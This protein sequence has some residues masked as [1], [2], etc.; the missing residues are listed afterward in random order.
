[1]LKTNTLPSRKIIFI[2]IILFLPGK[3]QAQN[4]YELNTFSDDFKQIMKQP[5]KWNGSDLLI[6]SGAAAITYGTMHYDSAIKDLM[7]QNKK[8]QYTLPVEFGRIWGEPWAT[9]AIGGS[10]YIHGSASDNA[11]NKKIGFEIG[12]SALYT[13]IITLIIK[14]AFGRERPRENGDPFSYSPF[15]FKGDNYLS[16]SS[17]H[18]ALAFS[19]STVLAANTDNS[20]LKAAFYLP[21]LLTAFSRVYQNHH[22]TSDVLY[23]GFLGYIVAEFVTDMH[24]SK[25]EANNIEKLQQPIPLMSLKIPF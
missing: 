4:N 21:A 6:F 16:L 25:S 18:T 2:A 9:L 22:W 15:S 14:F 10:L 8:Y 24:K 1:M 3:L 11:A 5:A 13:S 20:Y 12:E 19:L 17:G 7:L 23:G